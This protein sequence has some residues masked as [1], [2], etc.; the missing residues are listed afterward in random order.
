MRKIRDDRTIGDR[1]ADSIAEFGGSWKFIFLFSGFLAVW[2]SVN[3]IALF[4]GV[5]WDRPPFILLNLI[6]SFI[7]AFQAPFIMMSQN[8]QAKKQDEAYR[9]LFA[10]IKELVQKDLEIDSQDVQDIHAMLQTLMAMKSEHHEDTK[11]VLELLLKVAKIR[12]DEV[13]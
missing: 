11:K 7:A 4:S 13:H 9:M 5:A 2:C 6:L 10:E 8:R 3:S 12:N 1:V